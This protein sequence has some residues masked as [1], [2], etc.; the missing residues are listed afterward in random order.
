MK[1]FH[2]TKK[3][4]VILRRMLIQYLLTTSYLS[5]YVSQTKHHYEHVQGPV[6]INNFA[7]VLVINQAV[8]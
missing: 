8:G 2:D 5:R 1:F 6:I 4:H 7:L 3:L